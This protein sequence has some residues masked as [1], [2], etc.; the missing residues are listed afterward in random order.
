VDRRRRLTYKE[1]RELEAL[2]GRIET[3]ET[4]LDELHQTTADPTFYR[5]PPEEI[6]RIKAR[7]QSLEKDIAEAYLRWEELEGMRR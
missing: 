1:Q 6:V 5:Q 2:P 4:E 7:L 3:L